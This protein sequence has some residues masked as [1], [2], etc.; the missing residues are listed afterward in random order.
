MII[1]LLG[2][3]RSG[4]DTA[5][6][7]LARELNGVCIAFADPMKRFCMN[8]LGLKRDQLWGNLKE[9]PI[10]DRL[11]NA[12]TRRNRPFDVFTWPFAN[13]LEHSTEEMMNDIRKQ[14][15]ESKMQAW[16]SGINKKGLTPRVVL[17]T[18]G[19]ELG[20]KHLG[21]DFWVCIGL[22]TAQAILNEHDVA[23]VTD[24]RFRN[25]VLA[26]K[27]AGGRVYRVERTKRASKAGTTHA[28][29]SEQNQ[30]PDFWLDGKFVNPDGEKELFEGRVEMFARKLKYGRGSML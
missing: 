29:E 21:D 13:A 20:R 1:G 2:Q 15:I 12:A 3:S 27:R 7:I 14:F 10:S 4:K 23:I 24:C 8:A 5:G 17:Q 16:W 6:A 9:S 25:E 18:F 30:I 26:I 19:T 22:R 11:R 28:S